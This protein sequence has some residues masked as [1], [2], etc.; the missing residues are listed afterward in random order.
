VVLPADVVSSVDEELLFAKLEEDEEL[1]LLDVL[2]VEVV[3]MT[4]LE[5]VLT[6]AVLVVFELDFEEEVEEV[7]DVRR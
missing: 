1:L 3:L 4:L 2:L 6:V 7:E 5:V